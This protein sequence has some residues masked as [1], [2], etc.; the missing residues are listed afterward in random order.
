MKARQKRNFAQIIAALVGT[1][2]AAF[3][4]DSADSVQSIALVAVTAFGAL[5][6]SDGDGVPDLIDSK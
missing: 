5:P 3:F 1:I 6:D 4:P 2:V